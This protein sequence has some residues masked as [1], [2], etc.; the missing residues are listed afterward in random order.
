MLRR[1][2]GW[3]RNENESWRDTMHRMNQRLDAAQ[4]YYYCMPWSER[5]ARS[6][7]RFAAHIQS[8]FLQS[9]AHQMILYSPQHNEDPYAEYLANRSQGRPHMRWDDY[10]QK[11][12]EL[13]WPEYG[14]D[15]WISTLG[16]IDIK[17]YEAAYVSHVI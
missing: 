2:V 12:C 17:S 7:W 1:I 3:R 6:Q 15:H 9:W 8:L 14:N 13:T 16:K 11:F 10:L 5:F 4:S